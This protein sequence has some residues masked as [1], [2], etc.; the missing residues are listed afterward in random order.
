[1]RR[2][3][4]VASA[5]LVAGLVFTAGPAPATATVATAIATDA[6][7][8]TAT[9]ADTTASIIASMN[10]GRTASGLVGYVAWSALADL[11]AERV[12]KMA[13][14]GRLSHDIAGEDI[15]DSLTSR[16][17]SWMGYG[18]IIAKSPFPFGGDAA[19]N[20]YEMWKASPGHHAIMFSGTYNYVG[21]GAAQ[22]A[23]G[24][25]WVAAIM[26]ESR[27]HTAPVARN[28]SLTRTGR[29]LVYTWSGFDPQL[30]THTAGLRSFD[31]QMRRDGGTWR[32]V[33][34]N[35]TRTRAFFPDRARGHWYGFRVQA[36][37][38]RGTL[39]RWTSEIRIWVP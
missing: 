28:R 15:G 17:I 37:D 4:L 18:E 9:A 8:T 2:L 16:G 33:R 32:T 6:D 20:V 12:A 24:T 5:A 19:S 29:D 21:I 13:A 39:S 38:R 34:D 30:Q 11:A 36:A 7:T 3:A 23:D 1:M 25:T 27:D 26:T 31:V 22:S 35:T 14:V 10:A